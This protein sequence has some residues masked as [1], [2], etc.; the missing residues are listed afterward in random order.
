MQRVEYDMK[1]VRHQN[2]SFS[3]RVTSNKCKRATCFK[4]PAKHNNNNKY[5]TNTLKSAMLKVER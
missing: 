2:G 1:L 3:G 5:I 4:I